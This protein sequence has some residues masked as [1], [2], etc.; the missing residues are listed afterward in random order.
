MDMPRD[1]FPSEIPVSEADAAS[2]GVPSELEELRKKCEE[3]LGGWKRA[4]ADYDNARKELV[5]EKGAARRAAAVE[6]LLLFLPVI[7]NLDQALRFRPQTDDAAVKN[8]LNGMLQV[9]TQFEDA[10]RSLGAEPFGSPGEVFDPSLHESGGSRAD[11]ASP[12]QA[13]LEVVQRGWKAAGRVLCPAKVVINHLP[14]NAT[15]QQKDA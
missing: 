15:D 8:W 6:T 14:P 10:L 11:Q 7:D 9:R 12:D 2:P 5:T 3:Y 13:V 4:L 1:E